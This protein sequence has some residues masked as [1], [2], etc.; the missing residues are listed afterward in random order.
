LFTIN[1]YNRFTK[2]ARH[3][4]NIAKHPRLNSNLAPETETV[5]WKPH[6]ETKANKDPYFKKKSHPAMKPNAIHTPN[7]GKLNR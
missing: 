7:G 2:T 6:F 1:T 5:H 4:K 3:K